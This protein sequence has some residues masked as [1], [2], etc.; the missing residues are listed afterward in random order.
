MDQTRIT[1]NQ[2]QEWGDINKTEVSLALTKAC[3]WKHMEWIKFQGK[4]FA[5]KPGSPT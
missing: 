2:A 5:R 1:S 3:K 4:L